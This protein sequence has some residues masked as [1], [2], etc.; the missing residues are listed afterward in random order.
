MIKYWNVMIV[1][2]DIIIFSYY[3]KKQYKKQK[4]VQPNEYKVMKK[5]IIKQYLYFNYHK[6]STESYLK[7]L[8]FYFLLNN[9]RFV[10]GMLTKPVKEYEKLKNNIPVI[11]SF[12]RT[13]AGL[14]SIKK[15]YEKLLHNEKNGLR[16]IDFKENT[17][18]SHWL[19]P[20]LNNVLELIDDTRYSKKFRKSIEI[21]QHMN[22]N[23]LDNR[24]LY[25]INNYQTYYWNKVEKH[26]S[27]IIQD[28]KQLDTLDG[29]LEHLRIIFVDKFDTKANQLKETT[30][31]SKPISLKQM[32][33]ERENYENYYYLCEKYDEYNETNTG[34][35]TIK[36]NKLKDGL[37]KKLMNK[38]DNFLD[39]DISKFFRDR[40]NLSLSDISDMNFVKNVLHKF[41]QKFQNHYLSHFYETLRSSYFASIIPNEKKFKSMI[42]YILE[43]YLDFYIDRNKSITFG[44]NNL[45]A[46]LIASKRQVCTNVSTLFTLKKYLTHL[47]LDYEPDS[48]QYVDTYIQN[49]FLELKD[50]SYTRPFVL[51][52]SDIIKLEGTKV[53]GEAIDSIEEIKNQYKEAKNKILKRMIDFLTQFLPTFLKNTFGV[54]SIIASSLSGIISFFTTTVQQ[55]LSE[56]NQT[57]MKQSIDEYIK[58]FIKEHNMKRILTDFNPR[59]C[60]ENLKLQNIKKQYYQIHNMNLITYNDTIIDKEKLSNKIN[61]KIE[62]FINQQE[63]EHKK[64]IITILHK[65][66]NQII[67]DQKFIYEKDKRKLLDKLIS[68]VKQI[69]NEHESIDVKIINNII[70][71]IDSEETI[72]EQKVTEKNKLISIINFEI[73]KIINSF[74]IESII[75][76]LNQNVIKLSNIPIHTISNDDLR[77]LKKEYFDKNKINIPKSIRL[78]FIDKN[79][80][81]SKVSSQLST[82]VPDLKISVP[83]VIMTKKEEVSTPINVHDVSKIKRILPF[84]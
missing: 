23:L 40:E 11:V 24:F 21:I 64:S 31:M 32:M 7:L 63:I 2:L 17:V 51:Y 19:S 74:S 72:P 54:V 80:I 82:H 81:E 71:I 26:D 83:S 18:S 45:A 41:N 29:L 35:V 5:K 56:M 58:D 27:V 12:A 42:K 65:R 30:D 49:V 15:H 70:E 66:V 67:D 55:T 77:Y 52:E 36:G 84:Q 59:Y 73:N 33:I 28:K 37:K 46:Y 60:L 10:V 39:I 62:T 79:I 43:L 50:I 9:N 44:L 61:D 48:I 78:L 22:F 47:Q 68:T 20:T 57:L 14:G 8:S 25:W 4:N 76:L 75:L 69:I 6:Q 53:I 13:L 3:I 1:L 16:I 34:C 38:K